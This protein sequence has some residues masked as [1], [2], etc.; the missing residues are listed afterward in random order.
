M[1]FQDYL[2]YKQGNIKYLYLLSCIAAL[3]LILAC[4][5]YMNLTTAQ[6]VGRAREVGVRRVIG[7][8]QSAIRY[9]FL[10]ET[11]I[12]SF[13]GLL[14]SLGLAI[15][16]LPVFNSLTGQSLSFF[17]KENSS[18]VLWMI[19]ICALTGL[20]AGLY[21]ALYLSSFNTVLV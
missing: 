12:V 15:L 10:I 20:T 4:I 19:L 14:L 13:F 8:D 9:Q 11:V 1:G 3:I 2:A 21:P 16:F 7:A 18:L 6:A 5:N 17:A